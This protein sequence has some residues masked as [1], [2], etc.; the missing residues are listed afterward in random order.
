MVSYKKLLVVYK[1]GKREMYY[2]S[3][4]EASEATDEEMIRYYKLEQQAQAYAWEFWQDTLCHLSMEQKDSMFP[5]NNNILPLFFFDADLDKEYKKK[6][7]EKIER[8]GQFSHYGERQAHIEIKLSRK[9]KTLNKTLKQNIRHELCHYALWLAGYPCADD[10]AA[11]WFLAITMDVQPYMIPENEE[12]KALISIATEL[13][14]KYV[15][16][17]PETHRLVAISIMLYQITICTSDNY[18]AT[19]L[20]QIEGIKKMHE[21]IFSDN[22]A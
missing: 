9:T 1:K 5:I 2:R 16:E 13:Y 18:E 8:E 7:G 6:T 4:I 14:N 21:H 19:V 12:T 17:M 3:Y 11:F 20:P 15:K 22:N 10:S